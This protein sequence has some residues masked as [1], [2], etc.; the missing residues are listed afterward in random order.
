MS[1]LFRVVFFLV[2]IT[3]AGCTKVIDLPYPAYEERIVLMGILNPDSVFSIRLSKTLPPLTTD[4]VFAAITS[5]K[6][7]CYE[8]GTLLGNM[9]HQ[10]NGIYVL[11]R[12]PQQLKK[13]RVEAVVGN[14]KVIAEDSIPVFPTFQLSIT[15]PKAENI[16]KTPNIIVKRG[17]IK[18]AVNWLSRSQYGYSYSLKQNTFSLENLSSLDP[19][20]DSFNAYRDDS[21]RTI[22]SRNIRIKPAFTEAIEMTLTPINQILKDS[23]MYIHI[24]AV[25]FSYDRY[26]KSA[27]NAYENRLIDKEGQLNNPFYEPISIHSNVKNGIG[28]FGAMQEKLYKLKNNQK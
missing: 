23:T 6:V 3:I 5:A 27:I 24:V 18:N 25:S 17:P 1:V 20:L 7:V 19:Y 2:W 8:N 22:F 13:Y 16:N 10:Q 14:T 12:K 15:A 28:I 11:N 4:T 9:V 26:L 21:G